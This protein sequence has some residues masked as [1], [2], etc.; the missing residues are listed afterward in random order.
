M[1]PDVYFGQNILNVLR[2][3][4]LTSEGTATMVAE[5]LQDAELE[6]VSP[7]KLLCIYRRGFLTALGAVTAAFGL[8]FFNEKHPS[9]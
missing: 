3:T 6:G 9:R 4:Y 1:A 7:D 8:D 5:T 2:A